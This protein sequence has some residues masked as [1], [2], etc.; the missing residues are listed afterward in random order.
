MGIIG[1][2]WTEINNWQ[3]AVEADLEVWEKTCIKLLS[4]TYASEYT[5]SDA[6]DRK[7]PYSSVVD[8]EDIDRTAVA[9]KVG[10]IFDVLISQNTN[11]RKK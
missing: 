10:A 6:P 5:Q 8:V 9:K 7:A 3:Q 2:S 4:D 1:L 11:K